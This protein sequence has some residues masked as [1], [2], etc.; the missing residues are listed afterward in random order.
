MNT[1]QRFVTLSK[2]PPYR[3]GHAK[4]ALWNNRALAALTGREQHQVTYC[5]TP[6]DPADVAGPGVMVHHVGEVRQNP[7]NTDGQL[8]RAISAE[9]YQVAATYGIDAILTYYIDPHAAVVN[10]VA[11]AL[12]LVGKRPVVIHSIEGTDLID[13]MCE[14]VGDGLASV[15]IGDVLRADVVCTVSNYVASRFL[16]TVEEVAGPSLRA[17]IADSIQIRYP[18]LPPAAFDAPSAESICEFR[19]AAGLRQDSVL[20]STFGRMEP[21]KGLETVIGLA[22]MALQQAPELEFVIGGAGSLAESLLR[23]TAHLPNL[24]ILAGI[25]YDAAQ[26]LRATSAVG[27]FP[28][29]IIQGFVETFCISAL[30]YEAL[31]VPIVATAVGGV[32]EATPGEAALI[33]PDSPVGLWW[34]R[35][36]EVLAC[37]SEHAEAAREFAKNFTSASSAARILDIAALGSQRRGTRR[38]WMMP[39]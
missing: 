28:T 33:P 19:Q 31:G 11:D 18:G 34:N 20:V 12:A 38:P 23:D 17:A 6:T 24:K 1:P 21:E 13:S 35:L 30:E 27:V 29:K 4:Q 2:Y 32:P 5:G 26:C 8:A 9:L 37:R 14:H 25:D 36:T 16:A 39:N 7:R 22:E 3:S 15:L 10:R